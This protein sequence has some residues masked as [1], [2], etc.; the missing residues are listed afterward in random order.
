[1]VEFLYLVDENDNILGKIT[2]KECH[3]S[4]GCI[5]RSV[6][7]FVL[8]GL[9]ELFLQKRS[10]SKDLYPSYCTGSASGQVEYGENHEKAA[11]RELAE[12]LG[13]QAPI[14]YV[15]KSKS[16]TE[17]EKEIAAI[18]FCRYTGPLNLNR[19]E[20]EEGIFTNLKDVEGEIN[21]GE[22]KFADGFKFAFREFLKNY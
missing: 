22:K 10:I 19:E 18:Y 21:R 4:G 17:I 9:G 8:N 5:H 11:K 15:C 16:F 12:E 2:R 6:Y 13:I 7:V 20:I 14:T 3:M 1:M